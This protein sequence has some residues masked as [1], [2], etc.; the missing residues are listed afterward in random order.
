MRIARWIDHLPPWLAYGATV[1]TGVYENW[2]MVLFP[3]PLL[4]GA[5]V[6]ALRWDLSRWRRWLEVLALAIFLAD[7]F[8]PTGRRNPVVVAVHTLF[9]LCGLRLI[10][11]RE[12]PQRRQ[13]LFM[14][15]LLF[16]TTAVTTAEL[17]FMGWAVAWV[18]GASIVL[19]QLAWEQSAQLRR[20]P[21]QRAP[22][23]RAFR[24]TGGVLVLAGGF[25]LVL[26]RTTLALRP[27][28][29]S[30]SGLMGSQAG[31]SESLDLGGTGPISRNSEV[32]MRLIPPKALSLQA[33]ADLAE[34]YA[35]LRGVALEKLDG[36]KWEPQQTGWERGVAFIAP[37]EVFPRKE[38]ELYTAPSAQMILPLPYGE[39]VE[40]Q[41]PAVFPLRKGQGDS[42]RWLYPP[43]RWLS[44]GVSARSRGA[45]PFLPEENRW[46]RTRRFANLTYLPE[47]AEAAHRW[48]LAAAPA[49]LPPDQ[50]K[51]EA[52]ARRLTARLRRF[53]YT[54][55]NP[56]GGAENPLQDFLERSQAGHCEYFA[57][58]LAFMLRSRGIPSRVVNGYRL[59]SWSEE[60]GYFLV[61]Q[62]EAH[63]W[64]EY[65]DEEAEGWRVADPTPAAPPG[66]GS[67]GLRAALRR[68]A[69]AAQYRWDRYVVRF[70]DADQLEGAD[71]IK[72]AA[73][74]LPSWRPGKRDGLV[75]L[76]LLALL[77]AARIYWRRRV[78]PREE[79]DRFH[80]V[81]ALRPLVRKAAGDLAPRTG[82]TA[83]AWLLRL[84][85]ARPALA[86][87]LRA[88]AGDVDAVAYG[89]GS[90]A[91]LKPKVKAVLKGWDRGPGA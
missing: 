57:S 11:P 55:D 54:T 35:L 39:Q 88:L 14:G 34:R 47:E 52:L 61:T 79:A 6:E 30:L 72:N 42:V 90:E 74:N 91:A 89:E 62:N 50:L 41:W 64:V 13:L 29:F 73:R 46:T 8:S 31:L 37:S 33:R 18:L 9:V 3:V 59:G 28:P 83:K 66:P 77:V 25:F 78:R 85:Q 69:D 45:E 75:A 4:L 20:G 60:G 2:E 71:W 15:F 65:Y 21:I 48:S 27:M 26:P 56:S 5:L 36:T 68:W 87:P 80:R 49:S 84:A 38:A 7:V 24:W 44:L 86:G 19:L 53:Q 22:L 40:V 23:G 43:Q 76:G 16:I 82:E 51:P 70:S 58:S 12:L 63:A 67:V 17:G 32:V 81:K 1:S 10:L